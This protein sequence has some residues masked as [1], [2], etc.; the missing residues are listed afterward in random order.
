[1]DCMSEERFLVL[2]HPEVQTY[3]ERKA[4]DV[5]R[6]INGIRFQSQ[7]FAGSDFAPADWLLS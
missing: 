4:N 6:W 5:D 1:M 3:R 2:P 7:L